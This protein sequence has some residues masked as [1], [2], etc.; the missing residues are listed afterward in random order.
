MKL[1]FESTIHE[2]RTKEVSCVVYFEIN[3]SWYMLWDKENKSTTIDTE[4]WVLERVFQKN[5]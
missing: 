5:A 2:G 4:N 3:K 1:V